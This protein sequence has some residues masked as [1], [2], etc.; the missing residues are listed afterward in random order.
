MP[1]VRYSLPPGGQK[2]NR[3]DGGIGVDKIDFPVPDDFLKVWNV[4]S[5]YAN[6]VNFFLTR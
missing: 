2:P 3:R 4:P 5:Y 1:D 6:V